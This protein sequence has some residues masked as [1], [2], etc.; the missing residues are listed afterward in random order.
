MNNSHYD[1]NRINQEGDSLLNNLNQF[2]TE[3]KSKLIAVGY[4]SMI[5]IHALSKWIEQPSM[6]D[7]FL[8]KDRK[9]EALLQLALFNRNVSGLHGLGSISMAHTHENILRIQEIVEEE[10]SFYKNWK[11]QSIIFYK[12]S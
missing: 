6:Q 3:I 7:I 12:R 11:E 2:F 9:R 1:Y 4:K 10:Q 5:M 8:F